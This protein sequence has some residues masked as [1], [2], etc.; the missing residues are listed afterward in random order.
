VLLRRW[1]PRDRELLGAINADPCVMRYF[2]ALLSQAQTDAL[3]E[4]CEASFER[5]GYGLW[6][7][8][9]P[10]ECELAGFVGL[11]QVDPVL[12][13]APAVEIGW[14]FARAQWGRGFA[15]EAAS[16]VVSFAFEEAQ[17]E[18]LVATTYVGN[19][20]S[21]AVMER[22]RMQRDPAEDFEHPSLPPGHRLAPHVLYRLERARW[23][24]R[25]PALQPRP[26]R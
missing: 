14:R 12:P 5:F 2:P 23:L 8:E 17:L 21:R 22:L 4:R 24:A 9:L 3:I 7:L 20:R 11:E 16:R 1:R 13:C 18:S 26:A 25:E 6:A 10:G 19:A 15:S